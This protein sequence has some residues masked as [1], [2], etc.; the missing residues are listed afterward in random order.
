M[1]Y[2]PIPRTL[3]LGAATLLGFATGAVASQFQDPTAVLKKPLNI[4][5]HDKTF[6]GPFAAL[7]AGPRIDQYIEIGEGSNVQDSCTIDS[8][9]GSVDIG[10]HVIVA[11]GASVVGAKWIETSIG[12]YGPGNPDDPITPDD[13]STTDCFVSFNAKV[14]GAI[15]EKGSIVSALSR[16]GQYVYLES[17]L[18]TIPGVNIKRQSEVAAKTVPVTY[19]DVLFMQGVLAVNEEF[20][21]NWPAVTLLDLKNAIGIGPAPVTTFNPGGS[22]TIHGVPTVDPN[23]KGKRIIG[24]VE[25]E[26]EVKILK[27]V[28]GAGSSIRA[29]E[30]EPFVVGHIKRM[31][32]NTTFHALEH[33][34]IEAGTNGTYGVRS[35]VHGG[36]TTFPDSHGNFT[37]DVTVTGAD[38]KLG[39]GSVFFRSR[40][41]DGVTIGKRSVVQQCDLPDGTVIP[42]KEIWLNDVKFG[43]VEW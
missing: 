22:P 20:A 1:T 35:I 39:D 10:E 28:M 34:H 33:T 4:T 17:G 41:G 8:R 32:K 37:K 6:I 13:E 11:H 30:G 42:N 2:Q 7:T 27:K 16:V 24:E 21:D 31:G 14:E 18:K 12:L 9:K 5:I 15:I 40:A 3:A 23:F 29:D 26:D 25:M 19:A 43:D 36:A 38:F